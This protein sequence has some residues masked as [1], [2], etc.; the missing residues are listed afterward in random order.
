[1]NK[2][3]EVFRW[4]FKGIKTSKNPNIPGTKTSD[5]NVFKGIKTSKNVKIK[6]TNE[7]GFF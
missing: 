1:M 6:Q 4:V 5:L 3:K 2:K 7:C